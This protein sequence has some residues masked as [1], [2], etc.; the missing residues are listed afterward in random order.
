MSAQEIIADRPTWVVRRL[1]VGRVTFGESPTVWD[2]EAEEISDRPEAHDRPMTLHVTN[3]AGLDAVVT[4]HFEQPGGEHELK[5]TMPNV[6]VGESVKLSD[7][8]PINVEKATA[9]VTA[10]GTFSDERLNVPVTIHVKNL[11]AKGRGE[12][13]MGL[14]GNT[15]GQM[16]EGLKELTIHVLLTGTLRNPRIEVND[17]KLLAD[18]Q[19]A[20]ME[21]G[22]KQLADRAGQEMEKLAGEQ[23]KGAQGEQAK[24]VLEG[25]FGPK[26]ETPAEG[27]D[28]TPEEK[29][30]KPDLLKG[31]FGPKKEEPADESEKQET[32]EKPDEEKKDEKKSPFE[33]LF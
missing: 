2:L 19:A 4:F 23:L 10:E 33:G 11:E 5:I 28:A 22:K 27:K 7:T 24:G 3:D 32:E 8:L 20:L 16:F 31:L 17:E 14:D 25:L 15:L 21:A 6:A 18:T 30:E 29:E 12:G 13:A 9:D 1:T 26:K